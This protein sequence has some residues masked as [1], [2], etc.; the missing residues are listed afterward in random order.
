MPSPP[1]N[2][3]G[4]HFANVT[5][6]RSGQNIRHSLLSIISIA[7]CGI[8]GGA[9]TWVDIEMFGNAKRSWFE[10]FLDLPHGIPS[11]DT[12]GRVFR[13]IAPDEFEASF[14][15]WA[16]AICERV[17]GA[18]M[19]VDG[20][21]LRRSKDGTL[22]KAALQMVSVWASENNLVLAQDKIDEA[23]NEIT[24]IPELL[25]LLELEGSVVTIDAIG[26]QTEI[27]ETIIEQKANYVLVVKDNQET[28]REDVAA[29]FEHTRPPIRPDYHKTVNKGHGR[30]ETRECWAVSDPE[31]L[32]HI[33]AYKAWK[34]LR[35]LAKV[36]SERRI[37]GET[38]RT[39]RYFISSLP[40]D[41]QRLLEVIRAHWQI[42]NGL[43]WVL[44]MAFREDESRVRKDHAPQ[45]LAVLRHIALSLLKQETSLKVGIKAKRLR[46]GWDEN[47][48]LK[49]LCAV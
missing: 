3:I 29:T 39:T 20:K 45:N 7:I 38:S 14:R 23:T 37:D 25:R 12:F 26:C 6:P 33:N 32:A 17:K 34:G 13:Q 18:V 49:V 35:S 19:A 28:L 10:T 11:H 31:V 24:A 43:H 16:T 30:I 21:T 44:D 42:E 41:A 15:S 8:I 5:D 48:L 4:Q 22:G 27:A 40:A 36:T 9:D 46:A 1:P 2:S 47:Y